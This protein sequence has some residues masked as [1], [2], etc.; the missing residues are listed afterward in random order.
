MRLARAGM[1]VLDWFSYLSNQQRNLRWTVKVCTLSLLLL[2]Y[3][4]ASIYNLHYVGGSYCFVL[5]ANWAY[6]TALA[7]IEDNVFFGIHTVRPTFWQ[8]ASSG[9]L[10]I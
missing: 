2:L 4:L 9:S 10:D 5:V 1:C 7:Y 3:S 8:H 6:Y